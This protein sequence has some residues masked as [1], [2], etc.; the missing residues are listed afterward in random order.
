MQGSAFTVEEKLPD[1]TVGVI[2]CGRMGRE[3]ARCAAASGCKVSIVF[4]PD[5]DRA[6]TLASEFDAISASSARN[7]LETPLDA[8]FICV[9]PGYRGSI[10]T[11]CAALRVPLLTEKPAGLSAE[12]VARLCDRMQAADVINAVGY[13]NR[14]RSSVQAVKKALA[15]L[16]PI[17][18]SAYWVC[19]PYA[20]PWWT[21]DEISGGPHNEQ[22]THLFDLARFI[23]GEIA[24]IDSQA[25]GKHRVTTA[26]RFESGVLGSI[27]Y[28]CEASAKD[29]GMRIF[30]TRGTFVLNGW[31]FR[32]TENTTDSVACPVIEE[33]DIFLKETRTFL[34]AARH[35]RQDLILS[36]F[37]DAK[38][39]QEV[40]D[41]CR[42]SIE[43]H[44]VINLNSHA[45]G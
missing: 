22:A 38:K 3:R 5:S 36:N 42:K 30:T 32:L 17:A 37:S 31:D 39:T 4:D 14:Y 23:F 12:N 7:C 6:R 40:M 41:A 24:A 28:S 13:M 10:E 29:I 34:N 19:K 18:F 35:G 20:V 33:E 45:N 2:G 8:V 1:F 16:N 9:P 21:V 26:L 11:D 44:T 25:L 15:T 27:V 43:L